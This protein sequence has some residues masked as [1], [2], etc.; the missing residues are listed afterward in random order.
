MSELDVHVQQCTRCRW[1]ISLSGTDAYERGL[2]AWLAHVAALH[3]DDY[4]DARRAL[5]ERWAAK[6]ARE[7]QAGN[8][9]QE[10]WLCAE[11]GH[12]EIEYTHDS[13]PMCARCGATITVD[14]LKGH[15][16]AHGHEVRI[17]EDGNGVVVSSANL[18]SKKPE[19]CPDD[20]HDWFYE[21][22]DLSVCI[23]C[24][25]SYD[26]KEDSNPH[27]GGKTPDVVI[28]P[29]IKALVDGFVPVLQ[30]VNALVKAMLKGIED[31]GR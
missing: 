26:G 20:G 1:D 13:Q 8:R 10:Q 2:V 4:H 7:W 24:G 3:P 6:W 29:E 9:R 22:D 25:E 5:E 18:N 17:T 30:Q 28:A 12:S 11:E 31:V 19:K 14:W 15:Y 27:D 21:G 23:T 16:E